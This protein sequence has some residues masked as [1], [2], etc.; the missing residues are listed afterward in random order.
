MSSMFTP[1]QG[2]FVREP[3]WHKLEKAILQDW[4]G[5]WPDAWEAHGSPWE[6]EIEPVYQ[7]ISM[8]HS[9]ETGKELFIPKVIEG[10]QRIYRDDNHNTLSI[11]ETSYRVIKN[12]EFGGLIETVMGLEMDDEI[13]F[14]AVFELYG[15]RMVVA[16]LYF[17][18]PVQVPGDPSQTVRYL[19]FS[20][21]H[22]GQ[23]GWRIML[24]NV[25]VVCANTL[26]MAEN[27]AKEGQTQFTIRHTKNWDEKTAEVRGKLILALKGADEYLRL[28][29]KLM[30][31]KITPAKLD[32]YLEKLLITDSAM[33]DRIIQNRESERLQIRTLL[34][35]PTC[36]GIKDT[37]WG[38]LQATTEWSD[39]YRRANTQSGYVNRQL[40]TREPT[41]ARAL[42]LVREMAGIK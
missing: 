14:E 40:F 13:K 1:G 35:G 9:Q 11:Q 16:V 24:T 19:V 10:W 42:S 8:G 6:P 36:A 28:G 27:G 22:D 39:H 7:Q 3:S 33:S 18:R 29:E 17:D 31:H 23:G 5:N 15:G 32:R 12:S 34:N 41:K 30:I 38:L 20:T 37:A 25:R 21:R 4:P 26:G 2:F